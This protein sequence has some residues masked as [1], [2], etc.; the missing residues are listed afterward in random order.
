[1]IWSKFMV[2]PTFTVVESTRYS[3][4]KIPFPAISV[5][6]TEMVYRPNTENITN[7]L[8]LRGYNSTQIDEFYKSFSEVKSKDY[9]PEPI[10]KKMH[11]ILQDLGYS[12]DVLLDELKKPCNV[13]LQQCSWR[14]KL[15]DC[16]DMFR[17][18]FTLVGY[19]CQFDIRHFRNHAKKDTNF[20][21][22]IEITEALDIIINSRRDVSEEGSNEGYVLLYVFDELDNLTLLDSSITIT[23]STYSDVTIEVWTIDS[24]SDVRALSLK[25]RKCV[26]NQDHGENAR[27]YQNCVTRLIMKKVVENCRCLPFRYKSEDLQ[28]EELPACPWHQLPCIYQTLERVQGD[29]RAMIPEEACYQKCDYVQ[30]ETEA[31]YVNQGRNLKISKGYSRVAV[32]FSDD[33]CMKYR[34]EV[35]YTWDQMLANLGGIFGLCLGGS[36]ISIIEILWFALELLYTTVVVSRKKITTQGKIG[37]RARLARKKD[38]VSK[39]SPENHLG[40]GRYRF[41][42]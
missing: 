32:H 30:Y 17:Q 7:I 4:E 5:C 9:K 2:D 3:I 15:N 35:L 31:E 14:S 29:I 11:S 1:M 33:T 13:I 38:F 10:M 22:G 37:K 41:V 40:N 42:N 8:Q 24:S 23:P 27:S 36:I 28:V 21:S 12:Y 39:I 6:D 26:L 20:V 18:V 34:R 19:C 16:A 25:N